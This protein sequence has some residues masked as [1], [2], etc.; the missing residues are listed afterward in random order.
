MLASYNLFF[1]RVPFSSTTRKQQ[2]QQ[3]PSKKPRPRLSLLNGD[4]ATTAADTNG[5]AA[6]VNG[7]NSSANRK[8][9]TTAGA[10]SSFSY[11]NGNVVIS[12][13]KT[14][15]SDAPLSATA[16]AT[17]IMTAVASPVIIPPAG[18]GANGERPKTPPPPYTD[19]FPPATPVLILPFNALPHRSSATAAT[20]VVANFPPA[21]ASNSHSNSNGT[22]AAA[23]KQQ[24]SE[25]ATDKKSIWDQPVNPRQRRQGPK[26]YAERR[27]TR[28]P[29]RAPSL[30]QQFTAAHLGDDD[31][32]LG[33]SSSSSQKG[34]IKCHRRNKSAGVA[35]TVGR[36]GNAGASVQSSSDELW[37]GSD[38]CLDSDSSNNINT[39]NNNYNGKT[40]EDG[41]GIGGCDSKRRSRRDEIQRRMWGKRPSWTAALL[42]TPTASST[43][44]SSGAAAPP[45]QP[46]ESGTNHLVVLVHGL[47]G[48]PAD[49]ALMR[50]YLQALMPG[51]EVLSFGGGGW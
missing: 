49:M 23:K 13:P 27:R 10:S 21:S 8:N 32:G 15:S 5:N 3:S 18:P 46:Q 29:T 2:Q 11:P 51:A 41:G 44:G 25:E 6:A 7:V 42:A 17:A 38:K 22:T 30:P 50:G 19:L 20:T 33:N 4:T 9:N 31:A 26:Y 36:G 34:G 12:K 37:S 40:G 43:A 1:N 16:A 14:V 48:R 24:E 47:G 28:P 45:P 39:K 35:L